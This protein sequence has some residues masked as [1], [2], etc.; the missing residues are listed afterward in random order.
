MTHTGQAGSEKETRFK[1]RGALLS[2][3]Q[4]SFLWLQVLINHPQVVSEVDH[5]ICNPTGPHNW[6]LEV[7]PFPIVNIPTV[8]GEV[9]CHLV[10]VVTHWGAFDAKI[11]ALKGTGGTN[12][13][14]NKIALVTQNICSSRGGFF[15]WAAQNTHENWRNRI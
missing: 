5:R 14:G 10:T 7:L 1:A 2:G 3:F 6:C 13:T 15:Q 12:G 8:E 4:P 9:G 11:L